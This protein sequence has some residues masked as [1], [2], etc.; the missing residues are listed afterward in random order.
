[1][2]D[3]AVDSYAVSSP[4]LPSPLSEADL[5][6][7]TANLLQT[8]TGAV[9]D[10]EIDAIK[11]S[12]GWYVDL[13]EAGSAPAGAPATWPWVGEKG[14]AKPVIFDSILFVTTYIPANDLTAAETCSS[15]EGL[16]RLHGMRYLNATAAVDFDG[17]GVL[18]R[19]YKVGGGIPSETVIV[20]REGGVTSLIGTSGGAARPTI[21]SK[22]PRVRTYWYED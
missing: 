2:R 14:L 6:D 13:K 11:A 7:A 9:Y 5:Y 12:K 1:L 4:T 17:D 10:T 22:L 20:I 21:S 16:A 3:H 19:T 8:A 15:T 18:D